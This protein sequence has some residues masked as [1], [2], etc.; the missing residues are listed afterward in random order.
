MELLGITIDNMLTFN[1][2]I[3]NLCR[4]ASY[5]LYALRRKRK[6]L[7]L[8]LAKLLYNA[9]INSQF[10]YAPYIWMFFR[11]NQCLK[12]RKMHHKALKVVFNSDNG[13]DEL[14]QMGNEITLHQKH[15]H[16]LI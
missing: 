2:H 8:D 9:F 3:N 11:K 7:T 16:A 4:N 13:Y 5:K 6:Y 15:L 1:D 10:N 12:I 14:L